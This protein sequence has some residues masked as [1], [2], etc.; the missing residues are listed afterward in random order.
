MK[1][2]EQI[3]ALGYDIGAHKGSIKLSYKGKGKPDKDQ[4]L[5]LLGEL[6]ACKNDAIT[7]LVREIC[8]CGRRATFYVL[9]EGE[10]EEGKVD[11][12]YYCDTCNP[13]PLPTKREIL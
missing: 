4:V 3:E 2:L 8:K 6:K 13:H 5:P 9:G 1:L 11:W 12:A 10:L 7:V